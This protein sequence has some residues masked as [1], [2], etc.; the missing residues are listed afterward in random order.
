[1]IS[2][3]LVSVSLVLAAFT[4][5]AFSTDGVEKSW[6][7]SSGDD[8]GWSTTNNLTNIS[9]SGGAWRG[10][11]TSTD[12][13]IHGPGI[14]VSASAKHYL[15]I[16]MKSKLSSG[17]IDRYSYST[18]QVYFQTQ[19]DPSFD[20]DKSVTFTVY[21]NGYWREYV[22]HMADNSLWTGTIT[23]LRFDPCRKSG[24]SIEIDKI[25]LMCD[26]TPPEFVLEH[27]WNVADGEV[28]TDV[29]PTVRLYDFHDN[30]T[31]LERAE[32][33]RQ[34]IVDAVPG[35][36][37][38]DGTPDT[39]L[40]DGFSHTY[41][42]LLEGVYN[43]S[44][45]LFDNAG[46]VTWYD[47]D[48]RLLSNV[49]IDASA[50]TE[51][52]VDLF[53]SG[54]PVTE[55]V[56]GNNIWWFHAS[57]L[58]DASG[59]LPAAFQAKVSEIGVPILRYPA[60]CF[61]DTF[62]W[63]DAVGPIESRADNF[64]NECS[65]P[66]VNGGPA[67]FGLDEF[68]QFCEDNDI[69]PLYTLRYRTTLDTAE[70]FGGALQDAEDLIEYCRCQPGE[71][72]N[73]GIDWAQTRSDNGHP[74]PYDITHFELG[75]EPWGP[76]PYGNVARFIG[77]P[78]GDDDASI[79]ERS[80]RRARQYM[81]DYFLYQEAMKAVDPDI[82]LTASGIASNQ[83]GMGEEDRDEV[84]WDGELFAIGA[85]YADAMHL[86]PYYPYSGWQPDKALLYWETMA[87]ARQLEAVLQNRRRLVRQY[88]PDKLGELKLLL[89]EH[90]INYNWWND[91]PNGRINAYESRTLKA[92]VAMADV[93]AVYLKNADMVHSGEF[94]HLHH[95]NIWATFNGNDPNYWNNAIF[96]VFRLFNH[97]FGD[98]L[99]DA[100]VRSGCFG[101]VRG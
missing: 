48:E 43:F 101:K 77:T 60:G 82:V 29:S 53:E 1:M 42:S 10:E 97:H 37:I 51:I 54:G 28:I 71:N 34:E 46:N 56:M 16:R 18:G 58:A 3:I 26:Q 72:P 69:E 89:S 8:L 74:E 31:G 95:S 73:G 67:T 21:G 7:F 20:S 44:A 84:A 38:Q 100:D 55:E 11:S 91:P 57:Q 24:A 63:K 9:I 45:K 47:A 40:E 99:I 12:P 25:V 64:F 86:H 62:M 98:T 70:E 33:F 19:S 92:A 41:S 36:W 2:R 90:N 66:L 52:R 87:T 75:N 59:H 80:R 78:S 23:K 27:E 39:T 81:L 14:N 94:W 49:E 79:A 50:T 85:P 76:D 93:F 65:P 17:D 35:S 22:V 4:G 30:A 13:N 68:L 32:F 83:E 6:D 5:S 61:S 15:L 88:A 96:Y